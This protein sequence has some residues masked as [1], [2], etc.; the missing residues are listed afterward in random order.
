MLSLLITISILA[1]APK[2]IIKRLKINKEFRLIDLLK[3]PSANHCTG[4]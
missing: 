4:C 3:M 1:I 2:S